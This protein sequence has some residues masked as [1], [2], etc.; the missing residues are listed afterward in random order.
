MGVFAGIV[1]D[2]MGAGDGVGVVAEVEKGGWQ[3]G[4]KLR[5]VCFRIPREL[6][7]SRSP[8]NCGSRTCPPITSLVEMSA[9]ELAE[10]LCTCRAAVREM[11]NA[12]AVLAEGAAGPVGHAIGLEIGLSAPRGTQC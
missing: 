3:E 10:S 12:D 5:W 6:R 2:A 4:E 9:P 11:E 8:R 7:W 1:D